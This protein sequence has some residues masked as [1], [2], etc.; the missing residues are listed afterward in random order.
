MLSMDRNSAPGPDGFGPA[1]YRAAWHTVKPEVMAFMNSFYN[2]EVQ[3][4]RVNRSHMVLIP[5]LPA[6]TAVDAFWPICLQNA[7]VK[8]IA[9]TLTK[10]LQ[11]EIGNLI[12][13]NQTGFLKG[14]PIAESFVYAAECYVL[15]QDSWI[16]EQQ[17]YRV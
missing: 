10:R 15:R 4:E 12:D 7:S 3:L 11:R 14:R 8:I 2:G 16:S 1:F 13:L 17:S 6:A 5:K 9:K